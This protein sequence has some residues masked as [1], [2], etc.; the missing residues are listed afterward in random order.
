M[1]T[2]C[3]LLGVAAREKASGRGGRRP[4]AGRKP[5][6]EDAV[7]VTADL[8]REDLEAL[9]AIAKRRSEPVAAL[10]RLAVRGFIKRDSRRS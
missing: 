3:S 4:G 6:L 5:E 10:I 7:S 1:W 2:R 8:E 9:R